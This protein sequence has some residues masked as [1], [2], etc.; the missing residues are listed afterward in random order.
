MRCLACADSLGSLI[1]LCI[2]WW[3]VPHWGRSRAGSMHCPFVYS[4]GVA[5]AASWADGGPE[6]RACI[7]VAA[8]GH[9]SLIEFELTFF[10]S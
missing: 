10:G 2:D 3:E 1:R 6:V 4:R 5:D 9:Q 8:S 7:R